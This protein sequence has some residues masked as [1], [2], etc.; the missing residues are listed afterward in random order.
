MKPVLATAIFLAVTGGTT[1]VQ[2]S[3]VGFPGTVSVPMPVVVALVVF[4]GL[5]VWAFMSARRMAAALGRLRARHADLED[6]LADRTRIM[7]G[8]M[9]AGAHFNATRNLTDLPAR[10]STAVKELSGSGKAVLFV[11]SEATEVF[12]ARGFAGLDP[13]RIAELTEM[14]VSRAQYET[15]CRGAYRQGSCYLVGQ[16]QDGEPPLGSVQSALQAGPADRLL[17][18]PLT[19]PTAELLGY[20]VLD[21]P[22]AGGSLGEVRIRLLEFLAYQAAI[23]ME[24]ALVYD[25][26]AQNNAELSR[27]SEKLG[28]LAEMKAN[29]VANVSHELRTPL[30]SISA[31]AELLQVR[32]DTMSDQERNEFLRVIH[33]ESIKLSEIIDDI[34]EINE[35]DSG[36]PGLVQ[37]QTDLVLLV[38]HLEDS[39]RGRAL[40]RGI[41]LEVEAG[42]DSILLPVDS[43][44]INQMLG[45]LVSNAFKFN[46]DGGRVRI[47]VEET[48]TAVKLVVEDTGIGIPDQELGRIFERFYQVDSSATREH[49][50]QGLGLAICHDIVTHHDG[51]IWAENIKP[52]G[53]RF[54]V[55]LPRR[56][57]VRQATT[58]EPVL[59]LA[60][61][62][63]E[64]IQRIMHWVA[65]SMGVQV[66]SLMTPLEGG[67]YLGIRAAIGL[68]ES[69]V[70]SVRIKRGAGIMG[71]VWETGRALLVED[72]TRDN[73]F[74]QEHNGIRYTTPSLLCA[75]VT[76][77]GKV[78]GVMA[79]NNRFDGRPLDE[80]DR[81]LLEALTPR[82]GRMLA[83]CARLRDKALE[84]ELIRD[85]LR[86]TTPVGHLPR[87]SIL[88]ICREICLAAGRGI[89]L[90]EEDLQHLAFTL[91]FYDAGM[92]C[93]PPQL[94]NKPGP[95]DEQEMVHVRRHVEYGLDILD[96]LLPEPKV[97]LLV[98]HHHENYDGSGYP[99]GLAGEAIPLGARLIRLTDTLAALLSPRPWRPAHD[100]DV[101][102][103]EIRKG[104]GTEFCPRM[105]EVFFRE[106]L[107]RRARIE[108][109]LGLPGDD[110]DLVRPGLDQRGM[111]T[112]PG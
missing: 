49:N 20:L 67:E 10:I 74:A 110:L 90:S 3:L 6:E 42:A 85:S 54:T 106:T 107:A 92:N 71:R 60:I 8:I 78:V 34:L 104:V 7:E 32:M 15:A 91:R 25:R 16:P 81:L 17:I 19:T 108:A 96:P 111:I 76:E 26:L 65:E 101:A 69:V 57:V 88:D 98:L 83:G 29:F 11:W 100:L 79:V 70:Q 97:R 105:A 40:E 1:A 63:G 43:T 45:K 53:A 58:P 4:T 31:Y 27:A 55:L 47:C 13:E 12:A 30:T 86:T 51:R 95:L 84:F 61:E 109:L 102:L 99:D 80:D 39:W 66:V 59:R 38:R 37:E 48:G 56:P 68:P 9:A 89:H 23:A 52:R 41:T 73:R 33:N 75:P 21:E 46:R 103:A 94:L 112:V 44:M 5:A 2:G 24:S 64:F 28:S 50:G 87:E 14:Q 77:G 22:A 93:V 36:R 82:L 72:I 35:M 18:V 62:P